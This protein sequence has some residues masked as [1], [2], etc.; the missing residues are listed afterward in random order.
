ME[1]IQIFSD[2]RKVNNKKLIISL[3]HKYCSDKQ[4]CCELNGEHN[5]TDLA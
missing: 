3:L 2:K 1:N 5:E 4:F